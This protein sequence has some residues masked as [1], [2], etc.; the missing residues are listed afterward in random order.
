MEHSGPEGGS[1]IREQIK[2]V[3]SLINSRGNSALKMFPAPFQAAG[4]TR[5]K[6]SLGHKYTGPLCKGDERGKEALLL[7][8]LYSAMKHIAKEK[9]RRVPSI[10]PEDFTELPACPVPQTSSHQTSKLLNS[11]LLLRGNSVETLQPKPVFKSKHSVARSSA[12]RLKQQFSS[13]SR[14]QKRSTIA[15]LESAPTIT[16]SLIDNE[17]S[18]TSLKKSLTN[19]FGG[20]NLLNPPVVSQRRDSSRH[21]IPSRRADSPMSLESSD[22]SDMGLSGN[23]SDAESSSDMSVDLYKLGVWSPWASHL[24]AFVDVVEMTGSKHTKVYQYLKKRKAV[25]HTEYETMCLLDVTFNPKTALRKD[26]ISCTCAHPLNS[27]NRRRFLVQ[28]I[29]RLSLNLN[30]HKLSRLEAVFTSNRPEIG[31]KV[32]LIHVDGVI[33][34]IRKSDPFDLSSF[35][36][37]LRGGTVEGLKLLS[38]NFSIVLL[39]AFST[40]RFLKIIDYL[41]YK[42][43]K[44]VAGYRIHPSDESASISQSLNFLDYGKI[45]DDLGVKGNLATA[46]AMVLGALL[47]ETEA[48]ER[49]GEEVLYSEKGLEIRLNARHWPVALPSQYAPV[50]TMLIPHL[51][52]EDA[53]ACLSFTAIAKEIIR[54]SRA[55]KSTKW[56]DSFQYL[57]MHDMSHHLSYIRTYKIT[58]AYYAYLLPWISNEEWAVEPPSPTIKSALCN[59]H[60]AAHQVSKLISES[61]VIVLSAVGADSLCP[62]EVIDSEP[63]QLTAKVVTLLE[64]AASEDTG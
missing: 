48:G 51:L 8:N 39:S 3:D 37:I 60:P 4:K 6:N 41:T 45:Y 20:G 32:L 2:R 31:Q 12:L 36:Y 11:S 10:E 5:R 57:S 9:S 62:C 46:K 13:N 15:I 63:I 29:S 52:L 1:P 50:V 21:S 58:E 14:L 47:A 28:G 43:V 59:V 49:I 44:V 25:Y 19:P 23:T 54:I 40:A 7:P 38:R 42:K 53:K 34:N 33:A 35:L 24:T 64:Y 56:D 55:S 22:C 16:F 61:R 18:K 17:E 27:R 26:A 30:S